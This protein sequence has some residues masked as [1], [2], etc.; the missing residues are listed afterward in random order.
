MEVCAGSNRNPLEM[1]LVWGGF[2]I[3]FN[4]NLLS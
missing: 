3:E 2:L 1:C 4:S